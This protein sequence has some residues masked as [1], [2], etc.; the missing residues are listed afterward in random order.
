MC[1]LYNRH[2]EWHTCYPENINAM[3]INKTILG[4]HKQW[5]YYF[6]SEINGYA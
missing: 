5:Y 4:G 3:R 1:L 6:A 2:S